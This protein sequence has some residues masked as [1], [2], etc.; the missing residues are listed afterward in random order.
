MSLNYEPLSTVL[1]TDGNFGLGSF[2]EI[3]LRELFKRWKH[4]N[5]FNKHHKVVKGQL[6]RLEIQ[7]GYQIDGVHMSRVIFQLNFSES[8]T[9]LS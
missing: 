2:P 4:K 6:R 7:S 3:F 9:H 1:S 5:G 8:V